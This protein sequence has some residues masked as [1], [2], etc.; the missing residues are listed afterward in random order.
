MALSR[1]K[2]NL[3]DK[4]FDLST[5]EVRPKVTEQDLQNYYSSFLEHV[6]EAKAYFEDTTVFEKVQHEVTHEKMPKL[7]PREPHYSLLFFLDIFRPAKRT[8]QKTNLLSVS[9]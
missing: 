6:G 7:L 5:F 3:E 4:L 9:A 8:L 2:I 1:G